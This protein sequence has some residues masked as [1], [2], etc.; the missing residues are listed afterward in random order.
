VAG[1]MPV[2]CQDHPPKVPRQAIH[3]GKNRIGVRHGERTARAEVALDV[4][5]DEDRSHAQGSGPPPPAAR[6]GA[7]P[8]CS[9][10]RRWEGG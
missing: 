10:R 3:G 6:P 5:D 7:K 2:P 1:W 4:D 8:S 9:N